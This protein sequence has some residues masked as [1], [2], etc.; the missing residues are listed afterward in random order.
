MGL[1]KEY[2]LTRLSDTPDGKVNWSLGPKDRKL[3]PSPMVEWDVE[4]IRKIVKE[5]HVGQ[6]QVIVI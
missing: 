4:S 2:I 5:M 1:N 6:A 3:F